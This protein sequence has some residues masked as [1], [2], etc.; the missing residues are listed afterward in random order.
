[1]R[2]KLLFD[3]DHPDDRWRIKGSGCQ[4]LRFE[5]ATAANYDAFNP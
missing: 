4:V 5:I 2:K 1:M 3:N